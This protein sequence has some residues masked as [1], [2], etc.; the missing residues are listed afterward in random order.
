MCSI[1]FLISIAFIALLTYTADCSSPSTTVY[2]EAHTKTE[3][4]D[5]IDGCALQTMGHLSFFIDN[6][7][8]SRI[9]NR[10]KGEIV[11]GGIGVYECDKKTPGQNM[12]FT[13]IPT[14][15]WY[16][17][18]GDVLRG[19]MFGWVNPDGSPFVS[20]SEK[21]WIS[22]LFTSLN[23]NIRPKDTKFIKYAGDKLFFE[24]KDGTMKIFLNNNWRYGHAIPKSEFDRT[25]NKFMDVGYK[26]TRKFTNQ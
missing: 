5:A 19:L 2:V 25:Y 9:V 10:G 4:P 6:P 17:I 21:V 23:T 1:R 18:Y 11:F 13:L 14:E 22:K 20:E 8:V 16:P 7:I 3:I 24:W 12:R 15:R 26:E